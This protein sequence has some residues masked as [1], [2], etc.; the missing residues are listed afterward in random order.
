MIIHWI[1]ITELC[2]NPPPDQTGM[3]NKIMDTEEI[4]EE[5]LS[6]DEKEKELITESTGETQ[7]EAQICSAGSGDFGEDPLQED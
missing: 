5:S 6:L 3:R 2:P 4:V 1:P 7:W